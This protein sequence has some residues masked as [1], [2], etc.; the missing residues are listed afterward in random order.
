MLALVEITDRP[1]FAHHMPAL[2]S[3]LVKPDA[4]LIYVAVVIVTI[5]REV[6]QL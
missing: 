4:I 6:L 5:N 2:S 1:Y 3:G